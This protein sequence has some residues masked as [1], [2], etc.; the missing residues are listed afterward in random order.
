[1]AKLSGSAPRKVG[2]IDL[3]QPRFGGAF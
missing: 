3:I 2:K 1:M